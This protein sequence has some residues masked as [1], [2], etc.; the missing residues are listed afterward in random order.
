MYKTY[1]LAESLKATGNSML[2]VLVVDSKEELSFDGCRFWYLDGL[3]LGSTGV[4]IVQKYR[5]NADKL[6]WSLKPVFMQLLLA[7]G[8]CSKIVYLDND[9]FFYS[10]GQFLFDLL[11]KHSFLLTPHHY[12][13]SPLSH[14]NWFEA[15]YRVGLYN[16]GFVGASVAGI[17]TLQWWAD[18]C[19]YRCEKSAVRGLF[20]DQK[21]L[22]L[23]PILEETAY[24][25]R[26]KGCNIAGWNT[27]VCKREMVNGEVLIDGTYPV[28]FIHF[29]DTTIREI[30]NGNDKA[31]MPHYQKYVQ[32]LKRY[33]PELKEEELI[34][35]QR[36]SDR[37]KYIVWKLVT[38]LGV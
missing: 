13:N 3:Q 7:Q 2:H 8:L 35:P 22:D 5:H 34:K 23:V 31:L 29:N 38:D 32:S 16:A 4:D 10:G 33:R 15:N 12:R 28:V 36:I 14:Q 27:E 24:I 6:R 25:M 20:D 19:A 37:L 21:Y 18:C 17:N 1:A 26:H 30:A 9:L 11:D